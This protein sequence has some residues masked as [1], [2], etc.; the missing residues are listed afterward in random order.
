MSARFSVD[1]DDD[2]F[3]DYTEL[4]QTEVL[5]LKIK[6]TSPKISHCT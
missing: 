4:E 6:T 1:E 2:G 5:I 3:L